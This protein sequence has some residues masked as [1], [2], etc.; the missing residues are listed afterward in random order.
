[1]PVGHELVLYDR[2]AS[3]HINERLPDVP[4]AAIDTVPSREPT[5]DVLQ[6]VP[7]LLE[8]YEATV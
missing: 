5:F 1:M 6:F 4:S 8:C 3:D 2:P 7:R